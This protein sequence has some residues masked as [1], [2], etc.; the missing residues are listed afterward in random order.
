MKAWSEPILASVG[1]MTLRSLGVVFGFWLI[2][3]AFV[4]YDTRAA[5]DAFRAR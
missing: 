1:P 4:A 2:L 5:V 3:S